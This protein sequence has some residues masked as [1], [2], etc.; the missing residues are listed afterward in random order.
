MRP[1]A[2]LRNTWLLLV[3]QG[4]GIP[5]AGRLGAYS[6]VRTEPLGD[7]AVGVHADVSLASVG[8][9]SLDGGLRRADSTTSAGVT[10]RDV[11]AGLQLNL[12]GGYPDWQLG[13]IGGYQHMSGAER[14]FE[15]I[16]G[17]SLATSYG[18][19]EHVQLD[20]AAG[21]RFLNGWKWSAPWVL[22]LKLIVSRTIPPWPWHQ[23][24]QRPPLHLHDAREKDQ[25]Q[26]DDREKASA[27]AN[28]LTKLQIEDCRMKIEIQI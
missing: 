12:A 13:V 19:G 14:G 27:H 7:P 11:A 1:E 10:V 2:P 21:P 20:I 4:C 9:I 18:R 16:G 28:S 8:E 24:P 15:L 5:L 26:R 6:E 23:P 25:Q 3:I 17:F 22:R